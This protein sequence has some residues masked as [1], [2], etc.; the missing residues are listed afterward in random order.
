[1]TTG[2]VIAL[3]KAFGGG[4]GGSSGGG[5][6]VVHMVYDEEQDKTYTDKTWKEIYDAP[7]AVIVTDN[8]FPDGSIAKSICLVS[9]ISSNGSE[10]SVSYHSYVGASSIKVNLVTDSEN[11]YL[12]EAE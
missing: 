9:N 11:G 12:T 7:M 8:I 6:L 10:Y 5:V 4:A 2:E 3:I 1:M